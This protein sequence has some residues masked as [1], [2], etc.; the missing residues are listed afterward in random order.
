MTAD[1]KRLG[2]ANPNWRGGR[3]VTPGGYILIRMP[4]HPTADVRGYIYEHRLVMEHLLGR[5]LRSGERVRHKDNDPGNNQPGNLRLTPTLNCD[6]VVACACGC[7]VQ[8]GRFDAAGRER[9]FISGHNTIRGC[10]EG[11]RPR[12]ETG[13]GI[14]SETRQILLDRFAGRCAYGCGRPATCWDHIIPWSDGGSFTMAGNAVPACRPCNQ[15]KGGCDPV[16]MWRWIDRGA[17]HGNEEAWA[18]I[19]SLALYWGALD[20]AYEEV[21]AA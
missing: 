15:S 20:F 12:C 19:I 14:P 13:A 9:R 10:R 8:I 16:T 2:P 11:A 4:A 17:R 6:D 3:S 5:P 18:D 21:G 1:S 7:G